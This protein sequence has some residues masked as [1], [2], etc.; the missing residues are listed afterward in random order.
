MASIFN[1]DAAAIDK[2]L[3]NTIEK[4]ENG[5]ITFQEF[6][7]DKNRL[8]QEAADKGVFITEE[9][10]NKIAQ[11]IAEKDQIIKDAQIEALQ[12]LVDN[13]AAIWGAYFDYM[14]E[15]L[16]EQSDKQAK[17]EDEK[18]KDIEDREKAGIITK[19]EAEEEKL[20][21]EAYYNSVQEE[22]D[23]KQ[24]ENDNRSFLIEQAAA[25]AQ[26]WINFGLATA[27][28]ENMLLGVRLHHCTLQ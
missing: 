15:K 14:N 20:R 26:V 6:E 1:I 22:I 3:S 27:S 24:K 16:E 12:S 5:L 17:I 28:L 8:I 7:A 10:Q 21:T 4:Y 25:L 11:I 19:Q 18:Y 9:N 2:V 13:M 23:R